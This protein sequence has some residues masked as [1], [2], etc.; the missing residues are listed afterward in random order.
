MSSA[1]ESDRLSAGRRD[2]LYREDAHA[3]GGAVNQHAFTGL[4]R[5]AAVDHCVRR[6]PASGTAAASTCERFAGLR[7]IFPGSAQMELGV[8][9]LS[10]LAEGAAPKTSSPVFHPLTL[11][12]PR[13]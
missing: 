8:G 3:A 13:R 1:C 10:A 6:P 4:D 11:L 9:V 7:A 2:Q 12:R 5:E